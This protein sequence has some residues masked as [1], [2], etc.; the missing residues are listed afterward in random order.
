MVCKN[1]LSLLLV[2]VV[3]SI[4]AAEEFQDALTCTE[5]KSIV[6]KFS[7]C[8]ESES[9]IN[10]YRHI[11]DIISADD[12]VTS[13]NILSGIRN[14]CSDENR[15]QAFTNCKDTIVSECPDVETFISASY[16]EKFEFLC[17]GNEPSEYIQHVFY[18][19]YTF[20]KFCDQPNTEF[21]KVVEKCEE[22]AAD[23]L[24]DINSWNITYAWTRIKIVK[25]EWFKCTAPED[26]LPEGRFWCESTKGDLL[27][28]YWLILSVATDILEPPISEEA[29]LVLQNAAIAKHLSQA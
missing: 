15:A 6:T 12:Y 24:K 2:A 5:I 20:D 4:W 8:F 17:D 22:T 26:V 25:Q 14:L 21:I 23:S 16:R 27:A 29:K 1:G 11:D 9:R 7:T 18:D 3:S 13:D 10:I 19:G 28:L